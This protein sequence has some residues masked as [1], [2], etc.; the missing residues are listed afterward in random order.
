MA[1]QPPMN[2]ELP[3]A[4]RRLR[5]PNAGS[6]RSIQRLAQLDFDPIGELVQKYRKIEKE[7]ELQ[8]ELR[9]GRVVHLKPDGKARQYYAD[10]HMA[11]YDKLLSVADKLLR[12][13]YGRVPETSIVKNEAPPA[14]IV[15][16][17]KPGEQYVVA[18][19]ADEGDYEDDDGS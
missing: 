2:G 19:E 14:F 10:Q 1:D 15:N 9:E 6:P 8:E 11:I 5:G 18:P 12:Y 13:G 4:V 7:L 16:L 3:K 17:A